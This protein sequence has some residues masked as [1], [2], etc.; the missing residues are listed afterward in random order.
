MSETRPSSR[1]TDED[2]RRI[3][4]ELGVLI[5]HARR[6][7][8]EAATFVHPDLQS[9]GYAILFHLVQEGPT[10][11]RGLAESF[12]LDKAAISRQVA[13][14]EQLGLIARTPHPVDGRAQLLTVTD[15]GRR[16]CADDID[17][18]AAILRSHLSS[19]SGADLRSL[20][21]LL[22]R[23]NGSVTRP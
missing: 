18:R 2:V 19:W 13:Q 6:S 7:I 12:G 4:L 11:A 5:S 14:L 15:E 21:E 3:Q 16:R 8:R 1:A 10:L 20:G 9:S 23:L 17:R 22:G